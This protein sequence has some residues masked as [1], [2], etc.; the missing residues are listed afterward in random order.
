MIWYRLATRTNS[1][2]LATLEHN[3]YAQQ[4]CTMYFKVSEILNL[5]FL[6]TYTRQTQYLHNYFDIEMLTNVMMII[7]LKD[8][9]ATFQHNGH[10]KFTYSYHYILIKNKMYNWEFSLEQ[11]EQ[12]L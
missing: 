8:T 11:F 5:F 9:N 12:S 1:G 6:Y 4:Y 3:N 7:I 2:D 10:F